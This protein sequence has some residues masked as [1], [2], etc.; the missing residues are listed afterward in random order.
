MYRQFLYLHA[1]RDVVGPNVLTDE[2]IFAKLG[3]L[4]DADWLKETCSVSETNT[5][6]DFF[7]QASIASVVKGIFNL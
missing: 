5:T 6:F 1:I 2:Q 7:R 4:F 3:E